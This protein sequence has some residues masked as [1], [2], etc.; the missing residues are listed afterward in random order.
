MKTTLVFVSRSSSRAIALRDDVPIEDG[1]VLLSDDG[2]TFHE[3][4]SPGFAGTATDSKFTIENPADGAEY[5]ARRQGDTIT[6]RSEIY[7]LDP[8]ARV[9]RVVPLPDVRVPEYLFRVDA[10]TLLY[11][12]RAKYKSDY[13]DFKLFV[14][15][16]E[17]LTEVACLQVRRY[18][19]GG[20]TVIETAAGNLFAPAPSMADKPTWRSTVIQELDPAEFVIEEDGPVVRIRARSAR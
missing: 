9:A 8:A 1:D 13:R 17:S 4:T 14:G 15:P 12:S 7:R 10:S 3:A 5:E 6:L 20:T 2:A 16:A 18:R 11:V 19:D